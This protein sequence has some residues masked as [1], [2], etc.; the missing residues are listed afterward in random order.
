MKATLV[1][2]INIETVNPGNETEKDKE[3]NTKN[4][5][6]VREQKEIMTEE[7]RE[8]VK[9]LKINFFILNIY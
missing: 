7:A 2:L 1:N 3:Q 4:E 8:A 6:K 5:E 9:M